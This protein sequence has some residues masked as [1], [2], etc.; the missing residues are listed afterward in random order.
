MILKT[1]EKLRNLLKRLE[2][3][4]GKNACLV[5]MFEEQPE[6]NPR[7]DKIY[8]IAINIDMSATHLDTVCI[9]HIQPD[10]VFDYSTIKLSREIEEIVEELH[11][12]I[13]LDDMNVDEVVK[14]S[15][16]LLEIINF[17]Y[18]VP[19]DIIEKFL[20]KYN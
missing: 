11:K 3:K 15:K 19:D 16:R 5:D 6:I 13:Y 18:P 17:E 14:I 10:S 7:E 1:I 2:E 4:F 12:Q 20:S 8:G 9:Q